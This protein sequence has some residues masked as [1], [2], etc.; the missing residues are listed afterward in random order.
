MYF[1]YWGTHP[2]VMHER[3]LRLGDVLELP[4]RPEVYLAAKKSDFSDNLIAKI[5]VKNIHWV[6]SSAEIP[7]TKKDLEIKL[8]S[9][10]WDKI[11]GKTHV[12]TKMRSKHA[13]PWPVDFLL[14]LKLSE[15][16]FGF[17]HS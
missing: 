1:L 14:V 4:E 3:I 9:S 7:S 10:F 5:N 16:G 12:P 2:K 15:K 6:N 13:R 11:L 8:N 17:K